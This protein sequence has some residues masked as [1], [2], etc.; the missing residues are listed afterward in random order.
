MMKETIYLE[1]D[2][3]SNNHVG[4][5]EEKGLQQKLEGYQNEL[6]ISIS[7]RDRAS[8]EL[9]KANSEL[10]KL[11]CDL[12]K[13]KNILMGSYVDLRGSSTACKLGEEND[14]GMEQ[15]ICAALISLRRYVP[16]TYAHSSHPVCN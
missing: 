9:G 8:V 12:E 5:T 1:N 10:N 3:R 14:G 7:E 6:N 2:E 13:S 4:V 16:G 11:R 15:E